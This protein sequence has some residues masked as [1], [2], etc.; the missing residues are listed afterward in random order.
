V[1]W[2]AEALRQPKVLWKANVG[3]GAASMVTSGGR[4]YTMG[5]KDNTDTV[6]CFN[7]ENGEV[8]WK[9]S[10]PC[11]KDDRMFEG[12]TASTPA[13]AGKN[14][15]TLSQRGHLFCLDA[16]KG[17][18]VWSKNLVSD[19]GGKLSQWHY[20]GSPRIDTNTL[21]V[22]TGGKGASVVAL[23]KN[24]G[25]TIWKTG[26][27]GA[28]YAT[29]VTF[30][31]NGK[32][33]VMVFN[34]TG[35]V[36]HDLGSGEEWWRFKWKTSYDVNAATPL[37]F[38]NNSKVFISSGYN[39]GCALIDISG[40]QPKQLVENKHMQAQYPTPVLHKGFIYGISGNTPG[41]ELRCI[42]AKDLSAKWNKGGLGTGGITLADG[43]LIVQGEKGDLVIAEASPEG[44]KELS[45][46][47]VL[48][49][50][51]W[52]QPVLS[53]GR[54]YTKNNEGEMVAIDVR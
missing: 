16:E 45:R 1:G 38:D 52:V 21:I 49:G 32:K 19:F 15:Y 24:T 44:Y 42:D 13:V 43:R 18:V 17:T 31:R 3:V 6:Y 35:L 27:D 29:P 23:D 34:A 20:A 8:I 54:I 41:G 11:P 12:G 51:C 36:A 39:R 46:A 53:N 2:K 28:G 7:A 9:H 37:V 50:R 26:S 48:S 47:K 14:V 33:G 40:A 5:N 10:Y 22:E 4:L 30:E 25:K